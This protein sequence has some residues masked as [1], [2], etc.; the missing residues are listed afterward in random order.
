MPL[1]KGNIPQF[2]LAFSTKK[3]KSCV[4][5]LVAK[6]CSPSTKCQITN[7]KTWRN[8]GLVY[9]MKHEVGPRKMAF[10]WSDLVIQLPGSDFFGKKKITKTLGPSLGVIWMW[11]TAPQKQIVMIFFNECLQMAL[12]KKNNK[13]NFNLSCVFSCLHLSSPKKPLK[14]CYNNITLPWAFAFFY[15]STFLSLP[16]PNPLDHVNG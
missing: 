15:K 12:R 5:S 8:L 10:P 14:C 16:Q 9:T 13:N 6:L 7:L 11:T 2:S 4:P 1:C 3:S